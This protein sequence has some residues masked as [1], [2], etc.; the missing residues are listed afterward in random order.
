MRAFGGCWAF[1]FASSQRLSQIFQIGDSGI[2]ARHIFINKRPRLDFS[3]RLVGDELLAERWQLFQ[4][5][6]ASPE[7]SH[8]RRKNLIAGTYQV[9]AVESLNIHDR[10]R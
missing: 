5:F 7:E 4:K 9:I 6:A 10:V 3:R 2:H 8:V 1:L